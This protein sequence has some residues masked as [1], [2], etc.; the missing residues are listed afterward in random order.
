MHKIH[1]GPGEG[2]VKPS[3]EWLTVD[4]DPKRADIVINFNKETKLPLKDETVSAIYGSHVFEHIDI[5]HAPEVFLECH[6]ILCKGGFLRIV[7]PD[8]RKS[9]IE[10][11]NGNT[12]YSLF[13]RRALSLRQIIG[14]GGGYKE[15]SL[16]EC[17]KG[18]FISPSG[19]P[20]LLGKSL[21][22][23][24]AWDYEAM[25]L[26]L[27]RAGFT[28]KY[29]GGNISKKSF[30][31]SDCPDFSFEGTYPSEANE[32]ERSLYIEAIK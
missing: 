21:A 19:Q 26:E 24:N 9:I 5:F 27:K 31:E 6:R 4:V 17:L 7:I 30:K 11:I 3:S 14:G 15:K 13:K 28:D 23:Q 29:D 8:V 16:F 1:F 12:E 25:V 20:N 2:W 10:Y 18:D 22:H 32:Y